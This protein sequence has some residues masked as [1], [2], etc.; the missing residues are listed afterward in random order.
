M[1]SI[2]IARE[3]A[4]EAGY[5]GAKPAGTYKGSEAFYPTFSGAGTHY[6]GAPLVIFVQNGEARLSDEEEAFDFLH[7]S[8][9]GKYD[10]TSTED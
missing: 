4:K 3:F 8:I 1:K 5:D 6:V 10:D 7:K 2:D 9:R